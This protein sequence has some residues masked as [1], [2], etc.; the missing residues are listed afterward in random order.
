[1]CGLVLILDFDG[2]ITRLN[3]DWVRVRGEVSR[4]IGFNVDSLVDFWD[5]YFGTEKFYLAS[6]IVERYELEEVLRVKPYDD[7]EKALQSFNGKVYIASLQ[8][9]NALK[10]FLQRNRLNGY[11][12]EVL[13]REDFG[14][15]FR[16]VQYIMGREVDAERIVFVD[17]SRRNISGCK[18]LGVECILFDRNSGSNLISLIEEIKSPR[19]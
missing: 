4:V 18:P 2:V 6:R 5:K 3:V 13:G 1:M 14:S 19:R 9:R 10:V 12:E 7:V 17:D 15:K 16:Q 8:S 11:F